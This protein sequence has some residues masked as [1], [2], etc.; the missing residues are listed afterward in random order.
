MKKFGAQFQEYLEKS[1]PLFY[2]EAGKSLLNKVNQ[3][4][5]EFAKVESRILT[6]GMNE[7]LQAKR[8]A[9]TLANGEGRA[10]ANVMDDALT[11]LTIMKEENGKS[12]SLETTEIYEKA[13]TFM[14]GLVAGSVLLG[15][16][17]GIAIARVISRPRTAAPKAKPA[18]AHIAGKKGKVAGHATGKGGLRMEMGGQDWNEGDFEKY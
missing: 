16:I 1:S 18:V 15:L 5:G 2:T 12:A 14:L 11:E 6:T 9:V 17:L 3:T 13:R 8:E 7:E 10:L 4:W